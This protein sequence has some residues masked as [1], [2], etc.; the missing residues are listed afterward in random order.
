MSVEGGTCGDFTEPLL[1]GHRTHLL[2]L[3]SQPRICC[4]P[5]YDVPPRTYHEARQPPTVRRMLRRWSVPT[6]VPIYSEGALKG[7]MGTTVEESESFV[8]AFWCSRQRKPSALPFS[9]ERRRRRLRKGPPTTEPW[10]KGCAQGLYWLDDGLHPES[11]PNTPH[12]H[13]YTRASCA[14]GVLP[15]TDCACTVDTTMATG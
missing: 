6:W 5:T 14:R 9:F 3:A 13:H 1:S 12:H 2:R 7:P 15:P 10:E 11:V 8:A 4:T